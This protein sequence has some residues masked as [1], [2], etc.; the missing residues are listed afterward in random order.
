MTLLEQFKDKVLNTEGSF[1]LDWN[2]WVY[3]FMR[4]T[5]GNA[6]YIYREYKL[7]DN[8]FS[9]INLNYKL[10]AIVDKNTKVIYVIDEY[11]FNR[12]FNKEF[13]YP[14]G[15]VN[16]NDYV[17]EKNKYFQNV[18]FKNYYDSIEVDINSVTDEDF[19]NS[20]KRAARISILSGNEMVLPKFNNDFT[21]NDIA[22]MICGYMNIEDEAN[23]RFEYNKGWLI[24]TKLGNELAK[25]ILLKSLL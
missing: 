17:V 19:I 22:K 5:N 25:N 16:F 3:S 8:D 13:V 7:K 11:I 14:N 24:K 10:A 21:S 23:E 20:Q 6:E 2:G 18:L 9:E 4:C 12:N 15:C 1:G